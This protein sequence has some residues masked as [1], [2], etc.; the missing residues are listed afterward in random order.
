MPRN[1]SVT[2]IV[3]VYNAQR[4]LSDCLESIVAQTHKA[5]E[6]ILVDDGSTDASHEICLQFAHRH[7]FIK[8]LRQQ[9][10]GPSAARNLGIINAKS[11]WITFVDADDMMHKDLTLEMLSKAH[12]T[13]ADIVCTAITSGRRPR[14]DISRR[15]T[16][17]FTP[18]DALIDMLYQRH[19]S[20]SA[21]GKLFRAALL[22]QEMFTPALRYEDLEIMPR[23]IMAAS[24]VAYLPHGYYFYRRHNNNFTSAF[25]EQRLDAI[26]A[27]DLIAERCQTAPDVRMA[28]LDRKFAAYYNMFILCS[29]AGHPMAKACWLEVK[30]LHKHILKNQESRLKNR[31]GAALV[32]FGPKA[33]LLPSTIM[34]R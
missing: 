9:H 13:G 6:V 8:V 34:Y 23:L 30:R 29:K 16:R 5:I 22:R 10:S 32:P 11:E 2:V 21:C 28:A 24:A 4:F 31:L 12:I 26:K 17:L 33:C 27:A 14:W 7:K 19:I 18:H 3:A 15:R 1:D 20:C 25:S